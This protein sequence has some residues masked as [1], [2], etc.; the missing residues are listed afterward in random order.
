MPDPY[1]ESKRFAEE[2]VQQIQE[3]GAKVEH[4]T[5][6]GIKS[7]ANGLYLANKVKGVA[8]AP[9]VSNE[10]GSALYVQ[11]V[12]TDT[13][14][15]SGAMASINNVA[16]RYRSAY[17]DEAG[18]HQ[19]DFQVGPI[20]DVY[21]KKTE[22]G[23]V[24]PGTAKDVDNIKIGIPDSFKQEGYSYGYVLV[25]PG[26]K[27]ISGMQWGEEA[28]TNYVTVNLV[29]DTYN[30]PVDYTQATIAL[31]KYDTYV[32]SDNGITTMGGGNETVTKPGN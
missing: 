32:K 30:D 10:G 15:S 9:S 31:V 20:V 6:D 12:D 19:A 1:A 5:V 27:T 22:N 2:Q 24:V 4:Q 23:K 25:F 8:V 29:H 17:S 21:F 3:E 16:N 13:A 14:K 26:G 7:G 18:L 11:T 28:K